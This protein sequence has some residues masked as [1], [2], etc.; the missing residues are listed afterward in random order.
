MPE[1][2][3]LLD[4]ANHLIAKFGILTSAGRL[5]SER[6]NGLLVSRSFLQTDT[7]SYDSLEHLS[8]KHVPNL[9]VYLSRQSCSTIMERHDYAQYMQLWIRPGFNFLNSFE[10]IVRPF[11]GEI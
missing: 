8:S 9:F 1:G 6:K 5:W 4:T 11:K 2:S 7:L 10:Q 3:P